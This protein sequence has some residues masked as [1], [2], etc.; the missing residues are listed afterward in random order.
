M[1]AT[2]MMKNEERLPSLDAVYSNRF[3]GG[4]PR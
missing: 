4:G 1:V 3:T 2:G